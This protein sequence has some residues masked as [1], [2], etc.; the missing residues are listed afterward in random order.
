MALLGIYGSIVNPMAAAWGQHS[1]AKATLATL[2]FVAYVPGVLLISRLALRV[3]SHSEA[4]DELRDSGLSAATLRTLSVLA[5]GTSLV[6][7]PLLGFFAVQ[8]AYLVKAFVAFPHPPAAQRLMEIASQPGYEWALLQ[9]TLAIHHLYAGAT[10]FAVNLLAIGM[11]VAAVPGS[12][13][14]ARWIGSPLNL[15]RASFVSTAAGIVL[16]CFG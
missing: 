2:L 1:L 9:P 4:D 8:A 5:G 12:R 3:T 11:I 6:R 15:R 7:W 13:A 16:A 14:F 10:F